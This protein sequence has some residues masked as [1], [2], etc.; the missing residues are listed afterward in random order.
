MNFNISL[1][2]CSTSDCIQERT[3]AASIGKASY[4]VN[5]GDSDPS[6][7]NVDTNI[8]LPIGLALGALGLCTLGTIYGLRKYAGAP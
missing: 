8:F 2:P 3:Y 6:A 1:T 4:G 7:S 5:A